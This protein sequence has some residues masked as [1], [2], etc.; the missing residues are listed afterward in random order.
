MIRVLQKHLK[1]IIYFLLLVVGIVF[2]YWF[3]DYKSNQNTDIEESNISEINFRETYPHINPLKFCDSSVNNPI[4]K[5]IINLENKVKNV[6]DQSKIKTAV[7]YRNLNNGPW[8]IINQDETFFAQS[9]LKVPLAMTIYKIAENNP[10]ILEN[11]VVY[12]GQYETA[13]NIVNEEDIN[14]QEKYSVEELLA[15]VLIYS[16]NEALGVLFD[17]LKLLGL[18]S[19]LEE[20]NEE[21]ALN[22]ITG[23]INI[24]NYSEMLRILYNSTYLNRIFSEKILDVLTHSS[25]KDGLEAGFPKNTEIAHKFGVRDVYG[26]EYGQQLHD[27]GIVY[28]ENG[29][30]LLCVMTKG[31]NLDKQSLLIQN[32]S[33]VVASEIMYL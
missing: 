7:Y 15:H 2:G 22:G 21:I 1:Y 28:L 8:F 33:K 32:I 29:E 24:K 6:I 9:L 19:K 18:E 17:H 26:E 27:C 10:K 16:D 20:T 13:Q 12:G 31:N 3:N 14:T 11:T 30:H 4:N 23:E 5:K 25:Y